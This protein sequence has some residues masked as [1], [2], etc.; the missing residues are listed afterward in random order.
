MKI[1]RDEE[2]VAMYKH[3]EKEVVNAI[4][5]ARKKDKR[6]AVITKEVRNNKQVDVLNKIFEDINSTDNLEAKRKR[7]VKGKKQYVHMLI[8]GK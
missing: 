5:K 6:E 2:W 7:S 4:K 3:I 8:R 1:K